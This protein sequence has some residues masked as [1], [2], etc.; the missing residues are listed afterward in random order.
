MLLDLIQLT[1]P[2][3][4][5]PTCQCFF[6]RCCRK[7]ATL[8]NMIFS[9]CIHEFMRPTHATTINQE[10][11]LSLLKFLTNMAWPTFSNLSLILVLAN[12]LGQSL[13]PKTMCSMITL[14][15]AKFWE[16]VILM[17]S[18]SLRLRMH[19]WI[20]I[21]C[22]LITEKK[23]PWNLGF[24][25]QLVNLVLAPTVMT[26]LERSLKLQMCAMKN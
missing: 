3:L 8:T 1:S 24:L 7:L 14:T 9:Q 23:T 19:V 11:G 12:H 26:V 17:V 18:H 4:H 5:G 25:L 22:E 6:G 16:T 10:C 20:G 21:K 13:V 15:A 2:F